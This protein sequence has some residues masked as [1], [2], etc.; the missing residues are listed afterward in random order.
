MEFQF[1]GNF[2]V[3]ENDLNDMCDLC[4]RTH[5]SPQDA[6]NEVAARWDDCDFYLVG[7]VEQQIIKEIEKRLTSTL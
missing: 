7:L 1:T 6:L 4:R 3:E 2:W 5:C